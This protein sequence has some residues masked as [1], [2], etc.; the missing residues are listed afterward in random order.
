[1]RLMAFLGAVLTLCAED[2]SRFRGPNGS[3]VATGT[4]FPTELSKPLWRAAARPGK[5]SPVLTDRHIFL[6]AYEDNKLYTQ[7][8]DRQT[9]RLLWE[10]SV[11][12]TRSEQVNALNHAAAIS[13]VTDGENVYSLFK[14]YG[15]VSYSAAGKLRWTAPLAPF[16]NVM[17]V[18]ASPILSGDRVIVLVDQ[19]DDSY[20]AAFDRRNG[21]LRWKTPRQETDAWSSPLLYQQQILTASRGQLGVHQSQTGKR[22]FS[23]PGLP[24]S[25]VASPIVDG[26][27]LY[28]F[29]YASEAPSPFAGR[30]ARL[31][32]NKDGQLSPDEY[33][34]DAFMRGVGKYRGNRDGIVTQEEWDAKQRDMV[35]RTGLVALKLARDLTATELWR[36]DSNFS[37]IIPTLLLYDKVLYSIKNGGIL[38]T[39]DAATGKVLK[40]G[41]LGPKATGGFSA[42]PVAAEGKVYLANE[43]GK[44]IVLKASGAEWDVLSVTELDEAIFATPA[45]SK[46]SLYVRTGAA[47]YRFDGAR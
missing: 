39:F 25:V 31:D 21:E 28:F 38:S 33:G 20:I 34:E 22:T 7:C 11:D 19:V 15:L 47:L 2:W 26:D 13:P 8:F 30:L 32:K 46:G 5:S 17:G 36:Q 23:L 14:D 16:S 10:R 45:L 18:S 3:G 24:S 6:T 35:G 41:R 44:L 9:G 4:G 27:T 42:S 40:A 12:K 1:M 43:D 29:G 37:F